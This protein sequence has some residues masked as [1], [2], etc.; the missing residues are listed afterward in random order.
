MFRNVAD[1]QPQWLGPAIV[2]SSSGETVRP[3]RVHG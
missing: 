3:S 1:S 2:P